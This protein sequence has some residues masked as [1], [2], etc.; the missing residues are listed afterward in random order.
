MT[1]IQMSLFAMDSSRPILD[2]LFNPFVLGGRGGSP[3]AD[4]G[5]GDQVRSA[6]IGYAGGGGTVIQFAD[7]NGR[8][9]PGHYVQVE[10]A[11]FCGRAILGRKH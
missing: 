9:E 8:H 11:V 6:N 2:V 1:A 4:L 10:N 7:H 5:T 3:A